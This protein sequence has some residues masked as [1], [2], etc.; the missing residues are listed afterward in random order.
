MKEARSP[1]L[2]LSRLS[3]ISSRRASCEAR[4][5]FDTY[6]QNY[7]HF[8]SR[9]PCEARPA[10]CRICKY[11]PRFQ[12]TRLMSGATGSSTDKAE[13]P[14][15]FNSRASCEARLFVKPYGFYLNRFQLTRLMRGAT[16]RASYAGRGKIRISTHAPHARRDLLL[17]EKAP[18]DKYISTHAP[19]ARRDLRSES[20]RYMLLHFNSRA[21]CEARPFR[22]RPTLKP[23][24]HFNS[25]ASCEARHSHFLTVS[26]FM[27][28]QLTRPMRGATMF[29]AP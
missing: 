19:H 28:F 25:C 11:S 7:L 14:E 3:C 22:L 26:Y 5:L 15:N 2:R 17:V 29:Q 27:P 24:H 10:R 1:H 21:S 16:V 8:N 13:A 9:A 18:E 6:L 23:Y 4:H 12:L 20:T